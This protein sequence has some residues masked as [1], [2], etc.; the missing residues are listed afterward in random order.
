MAPGHTERLI[1]NFLRREN[2]A[3]NAIGGRGCFIRRLG[4]EKEE[5]IYL[6][7][8]TVWSLPSLPSPLTTFVAVRGSYRE[9]TSNNT[10]LDGIATCEIPQEGYSTKGRATFR[11]RINAVQFFT[12]DTK[13]N[14][15]IMSQGR[16]IVVAAF[17]YIDLFVRFKSRLNVNKCKF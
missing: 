2:S 4:V 6:T 8:R 1:E 9:S 5:S 7:C 17:L 3:H 15:R 12:R 10:V 14:V 13:N 16:M 11:E